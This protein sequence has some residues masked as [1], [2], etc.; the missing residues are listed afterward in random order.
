M[1]KK[2]IKI[3]KIVFSII[4]LIAIILLF[5]YIYQNKNA[6][7]TYFQKYSECKAKATENPI[8]SAGGVKSVEELKFVVSCFENKGCY[9]P[10]ANPE[11]SDY[12]GINFTEMFTSKPTTSDC[13]KR[14][15]YSPDNFK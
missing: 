7:D 10:C 3:L 15:Y 12:P 13:A 9:E 11:E 4:V 6:K 1:D 14:C 5:T 2:T 8:R